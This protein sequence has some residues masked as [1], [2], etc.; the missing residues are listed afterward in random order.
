MGTKVYR[1][2]VYEK[3]Q[4]DREAASRVISSFFTNENIPAEIHRFFDTDGLIDAFRHNVYTAVFI[5]MDSMS[6]VDAA[7]IIKKFAPKCALVII[8]S[9][10]DY[11]MEGYRL[12]AFDY[13]MKSIDEEKIDSALKRL[14]KELKLLRETVIIPEYELGGI[15]AA[16][17]L[18]LDEL[19][20]TITDKKEIK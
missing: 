8:S 6:E 2:A 13:W 16:T 3:E 20:N 17:G 7:W 1:F 9:S 11:A 10:R 14:V 4:A 12:D 18:P 19:R 15:A 5:G